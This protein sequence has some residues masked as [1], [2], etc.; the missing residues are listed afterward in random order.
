MTRLQHPISLVY[1][2]VSELSQ[3]REVRVRSREFPEPSGRGDYHL[4]PAGELALLL[5][6]RQTADN[7]LQI[8]EGGVMREGVRRKVMMVIAALGQNSK[9]SSLFSSCIDEFC[10]YLTMRVAILDSRWVIIK[11]ANTPL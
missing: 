5:H 10:G 2:Q 11:V 4:W 6:L 9:F 1:H 3:A 8:F 7:S